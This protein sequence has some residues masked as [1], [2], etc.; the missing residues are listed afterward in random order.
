[1]QRLFG[2]D[3]Q[4]KVTLQDNQ[5]ESLTLSR[6]GQT[7]FGFDS[8]SQGARE[9]IAA[10][11][12]LALAEI[13]AESHDGSLPIVFDDAFAHSDP[14]RV[15]RLQSMLDLAATRGLQVLLL[16]CTPA[17]YAQLGAK[18]VRLN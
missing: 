17:D 4:V 12:R 11:F 15:Q 16:T 7:T 1:L 9:Q 18:E 10:A 6:G 3:V 14:D 8:L 5:F 13:L 2:H